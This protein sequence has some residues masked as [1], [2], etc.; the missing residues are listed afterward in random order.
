MCLPLYLTC[1]GGLY[2]FLYS[3][4]KCT[5][6]SLNLFFVLCFVRVMRKVT[7]MFPMEDEIQL[8]QCHQNQVWTLPSRHKTLHSIGTD[9]VSSMDDD[10]Q[11]QLTLFHSWR[12]WSPVTCV[13]SP[14]T[15]PIHP[16]CCCAWLK[17]STLHDIQS[18]VL[19][20]PPLPKPSLCKTKKSW[21]WVIP[22]FLLSIQNY[23]RYE[24]GPPPHR[25]E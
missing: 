10:G 21:G 13:R 2:P 4:P 3:E 9:L 18:V 15:L 8:C 7:K 24:K 11:V 22:W 14:N 19:L 12:R 16:G 25:E 1:H 20:L 5:F 17:P 6:S 23:L